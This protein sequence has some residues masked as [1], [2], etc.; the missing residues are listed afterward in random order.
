M[1]RT[2][3]N[4]MALPV[5]VGSLESYIQAGNR[6]PLLSFQKERELARKFKSENDV[7]AARQLVLSHLRPVVAIAPGYM[8]YELPRGNL[9]QEGN[10]RLLIADKRS[11][12]EPGVRLG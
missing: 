12:R 2:N 1:T 5:P 10:I 7:E 3:T 11:D 6:F 9:I 4:A 8:G